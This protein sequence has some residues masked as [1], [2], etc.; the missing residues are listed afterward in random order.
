MS[1]IQSSI[2]R[3]LKN[4]ENLISHKGKE[5]NQRQQLRDDTDVEI[6]RQRL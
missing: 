1:R 5:D 6:I 4:Q 2:Y 3:H